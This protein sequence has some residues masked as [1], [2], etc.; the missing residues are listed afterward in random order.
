MSVRV[1]SSSAVNPESPSRGLPF[2]AGSRTA[3]T[4]RVIILA[5]IVRRPPAI[6]L[7]TLV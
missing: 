1:Y 4:W 2:G 5:Q 3:H 6:L 7:S